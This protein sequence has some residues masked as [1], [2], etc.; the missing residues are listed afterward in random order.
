MANMLANNCLLTVQI[1][2]TQSNISIHLESCFWPP[3]ECKSN[4]HSPFSSVREISGSLSA[5]CSTSAGS[6]QWIYFAENSCL[7]LLLLETT[8]MRAMRVNQTVKLQAVKPKTMSSKMLKCK[9]ECKDT[10]YNCF[11]LI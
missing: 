1:Q 4:I 8:L 10:D 3:D 7:Q 6:V 2:Q 9:N 5:K 11:K